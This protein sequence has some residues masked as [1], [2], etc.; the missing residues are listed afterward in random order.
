MPLTPFEDFPRSQIGLTIKSFIGFGL[1][2]L[3]HTYTIGPMLGFV[4]QILQVF[5]DGT[6]L[7]SILFELRQQ[8]EKIRAFV[9][10]GPSGFPLHCGVFVHTY[11]ITLILAVS[12]PV[13][14][15]S[16]DALSSIR[17]DTEHCRLL[18]FR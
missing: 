18:R 11:T 1:L 7:F 17:Q 14:K 12:S 5:V 10:S 9:G 13:P 2:F 8:M 16:H 6:T 3:L 15:E 4:K